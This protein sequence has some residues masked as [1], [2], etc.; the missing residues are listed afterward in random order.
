[1]AF[2]NWLDFASRQDDFYRKNR[3]SGA[4]L[5][6]HTVSKTFEGGHRNDLIRKVCESPEKCGVTHFPGD[7]ACPS[8]QPYKCDSEFSQKFLTGG[9]KAGFE[10]TFGHAGDSDISDDIREFTES[11]GFFFGNFDVIH[12]RNGR[13]VDGAIDGMVNVG[14]LHKPL[15]D[16]EKCHHVGRWYGRVMGMVSLPEQGEK[17]LL[18]GSL[19][20]DVHYNLTSSWLE[21]KFAGT[22]EGMLIRECKREGK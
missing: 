3:F 16:V 5:V 8:L 7:F 4:P 15:D 9:L 22:L 20:F 17:A 13:I 12:N 18:T 14:L 1:M 2:E 11:R 21:I 19:A 10:A 6:T